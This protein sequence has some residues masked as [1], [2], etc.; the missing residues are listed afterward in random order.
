MQNLFTFKIKKIT[1][2]SASNHD[3]IIESAFKLL[4]AYDSCKNH[5]A[6]KQIAVRL[7]LK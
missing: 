6:L 4:A 2:T 3:K 7:E 1:F 5:E